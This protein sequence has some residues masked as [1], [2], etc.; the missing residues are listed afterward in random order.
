MTSREVCISVRFCIANAP[1]TGYGLDAVATFL[2][3]WADRLFACVSPGISQKARA[4][5]GSGLGDIRHMG[6]GLLD[7]TAIITLSHQSGRDTNPVGT[8]PPH[9][10]RFKE[11]TSYAFPVTDWP[12]FQS[13]RMNQEESG[14]QPL[15]RTNGT[16]TKHQSGGRPLRADSAYNLEPSVSIDIIRPFLESLLLSEYGTIKPGRDRRGLAGATRL[17]YGGHPYSH[18]FSATSEL[19]RRV[20]RSCPTLLPWRIHQ[21]LVGFC[22]LP[23]R[24]EPDELQTAPC[25]SHRTLKLHLENGRMVQPDAPSRCPTTSQTLTRVDDLKSAVPLAG[26]V[27]NPL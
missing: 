26:R 3:H 5:A 11:L 18:Q 19:P 7:E 2:W 17:R 27:R 10:S 14:V 21:T 23:A 9:S 4:S 25:F 22:R 24:G 8:N 13:N 20:R 15:S 12:P 1:Q 6:P 16:E